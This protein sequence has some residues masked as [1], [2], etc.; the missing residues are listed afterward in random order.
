MATINVCYCTKIH[1]LPSLNLGGGSR[2][3]GRL[4][5]LPEPPCGP[6]S[7]SQ[8]HV[9]RYKQQDNTI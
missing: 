5:S 1:I 3:A 6:S 8:T 9:T 7:F 2:R 4:A